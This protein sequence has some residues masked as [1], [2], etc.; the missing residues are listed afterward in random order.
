MQRFAVSMILA[1]GLLM[2]P[3]LT[4]GTSA[5]GISD[6]YVAGIWH[7]T[8]SGEGFE[9][10]ALMILNALDGGVVE[11]TIEW[12]VLS[13]PA[14]RPE[15][16]QIGVMGVERIR[17]TFYADLGLLVLEGYSKDDPK[18]VIGLDRYRL[19]IA[20]NGETLGGISRGSKRRWEGRFFLTR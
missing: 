7:G 12:T 13:A 6:K 1:I 9:Y 16:R 20:E 18:H 8:W 11:G 5:Q 17:G 3:G 19:V 10:R 14:N 15:A 4:L 2:M